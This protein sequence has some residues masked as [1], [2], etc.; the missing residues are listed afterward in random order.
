VAVSVEEKTLVKGAPTRCPYC[1]DECAPEGSVVCQ[2]CLARHHE[3]CWGEAA[4]CGAC[5]SERHLAPTARPALT[6]ER[7]ERL[8]SAAGHDVAEAEALLAPRAA[9][10][11]PTLGG[12]AAVVL[13]L[14]AC[15][16]AVWG[17]D[18]TALV[19]RQG[20]WGPEPRWSAIGFGALLLLG[21]LGA[22]LTLVRGRR[23]AAVGSLFCLA[24]GAFAGVTISGQSGQG[25][26][27]DAIGVWGCLGL[28]GAWLGAIAA[29]SSLWG[30]REKT[31]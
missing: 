21:P 2:D 31:R 8:L 17:F 4:R 23:A 9:G 16:I 25:L 10:F 19:W 24:V 11:G 26:P 20:L 30:S 12:V 28:F 29:G 1:H 15:A 13:S 5:A 3:A 18:E 7:L 27:L 14:I 22:A 6:R